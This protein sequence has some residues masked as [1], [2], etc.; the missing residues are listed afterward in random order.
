MVPQEARQVLL[1]LTCPYVPSPGCFPLHSVQ[2][3]RIEGNMSSITNLA[4]SPSEDQLALT[5]SNN[6]IY[7]Y[8]WVCVCTYAQNI[9]VRV[10]SVPSF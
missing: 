10:T 7:R 5:T 6:Q 1:Y 4:V 9:I 8:V 2:T 3:F